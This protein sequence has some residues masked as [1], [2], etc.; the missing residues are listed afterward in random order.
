MVDL[1]KV[2]KVYATQNGMDIRGFIKSMKDSGLLDEHFTKVDADLAFCKCTRHT[3]KIG[4]EDRVKA[5]RT[6]VAPRRSVSEQAVFEQ[7]AAVAAPVSRPEEKRVA[8][9]ERFFSDITTYT[10]VHRRA[11]MEIDNAT[12]S[13]PRRAVRTCSHDILT[14]ARSASPRG[15]ER[16]FYDK[17]TYTG[18]HRNGGPTVMG[19]GLPKEGF[20]D[21]SEVGLRA[22][23]SKPRRRAQSAQPE[24]RES[25]EHLR[26]EAC[27][28]QEAPGQA[29]CASLPILLGQSRQG[30]K[31]AFNYAGSIT[32]WQSAPA[33]T[34]K[35]FKGKYV[36][37]ELS[38]ASLIGTRFIP[39]S[40]V[41]PSSL[42]LS[43]GSIPSS[44]LE[45][46][47]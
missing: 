25:A 20:K 32:R 8:G 1:A 23:T 12:T 11:R 34:P 36:Q 22:E 5:G 38:A 42:D 31:L 19:N 43:V 15:P 3:R 45:S 33:K 6:F 39:V 21:L 26:K 2:F 37:K 27:T 16:F 10:G 7:L 13:Q 46:S 30:A 4:F 17:S 35:D 9:P 29:S 18:T 14:G 47:D 40:P 41:L 24:R 44:L 28:E